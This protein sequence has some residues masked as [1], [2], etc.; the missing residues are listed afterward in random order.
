MPYFLDYWATIPDSTLADDPLIITAGV[1]SVNGAS[2]DVVLDYADV[3]ALSAANGGGDTINTLT[4]VTGAT[5]I[6]LTSGNV[7]RISSTSGNYT[8]GTPSGLV[9]GAAA[10][11]TLI[12]TTTNTGNTPTWFANITWAAGTPQIT[13]TGG[14]TQIFTFLSVN[15]GTN[16]YGWHLTPTARLADVSFSRSGTLTVATSAFRIYNDSGETRTITSV[17]ASVGTAP[18]G[19]AILVDVNKNGS[20]IFTTQGDR[21]SIAIS[22]NT[23]TA[24]PNVT[25]WASGDYLTVDVDQI[26]STIAGADLTVTVVYQ[27]GG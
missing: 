16:W 22:G 27:Q 23:D 26:G 19:A 2:G 21:P 14:T 20:T 15:D 8:L 24:T 12:I 11:F 6:N 4:S 10:A 17:R 3:G 25:S 9:S 13:W 7:V 18:T 1:G 5:A